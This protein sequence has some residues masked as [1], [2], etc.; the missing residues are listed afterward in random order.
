MAEKLPKEVSFLI[1]TVTSND[2]ESVKPGTKLRLGNLFL[3]VYDA[4]HKAKLEVW[5]TLPL[6]V[7]LDIP[8]G[9]YILGLNL[10]YIP[11]LKRIQFVKILQAQRTRIKYIDIAKAWQKAEIP[12]AYANLAIRK[13]LVNHIRSNIKI[14]EDPEDQMKIVKNVL[15]I[16]KK[17]DMTRVYRDIEKKLSRQRKE[18]KKK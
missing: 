11:Y 5:D 18:I 2:Y 14:F 13:Y 15:P 17:Q 7:L 16:F 1:D 3:Y 9:K 6:V 4:K 10:H 8:Q 12:R